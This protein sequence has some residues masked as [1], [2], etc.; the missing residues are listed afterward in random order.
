MDIVQFLKYNFGGLLYFWSAWIIITFGTDY[1]GSVRAYIL[2][3]LVGLT[4]NY[5]VQRFWTFDKSGKTILSSGWKFILLTVVN[6]GLGYLLLQFLVKIGI[7]L[8]LAQFGN[9]GF[10]TI[11]NWFFYKYWVFKIR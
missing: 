1:F 8:W 11:W 2:G 3:N 9:A 5:L 7:P 4:L 6:L 10:F